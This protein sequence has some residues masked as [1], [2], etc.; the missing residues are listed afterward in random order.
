MNVF[1]DPAEIVGLYTLAI[2]LNAA[3]LLWA[4]GMAFRF[5]TIQAAPLMQLPVF[6]LLFFAPVYVPLDLLT[7]WIE[8]L[9][10]Y[11]PIT[12]ML[13]AGRS[14]LAGAP[15]EIALAFALGIL[16]IGGFAVW[17]F[18]GLRR[19]EAAG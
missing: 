8:T 15:T 3:A 7:G 13:E 6:L 4:A 14:L 19:A 16:M 2:L 1:G 18:R 11:N 9:A 12:Y 10:T 17:A 5:R